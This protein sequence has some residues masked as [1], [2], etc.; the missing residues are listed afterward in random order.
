MPRVKG[1]SLTKRDVIQAAVS[2]VKREGPEALGINR[3]ARELGIRPPSLYNHVASREELQRGVAAEAWARLAE[4]F[5]QARAQGGE[6]VQMLRALLD[7]YRQFALSNTALYDI[8]VHTELD[9]SDPQIGTAAR[10]NIAVF[11]EVLSLF[12]ISGDE[13]IHAIRS[14]RAA[15]GGFFLLERHGGFGMP[16]SRAAT[17]EWMRECFIQALE[18]RRAR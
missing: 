12:G 7:A 13:A 3:V 18:A 2:C 14:F 16:Q 17:Y 1:Q 6:P 11:V 9:Y 5:K 15:M 8:M 4:R 10:A